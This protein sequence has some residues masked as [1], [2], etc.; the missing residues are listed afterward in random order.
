MDGTLDLSFEAFRIWTTYR[1]QAAE[2]GWPPTS[3]KMT[4]CKRG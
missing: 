3:I 4:D 2:D 1:Q